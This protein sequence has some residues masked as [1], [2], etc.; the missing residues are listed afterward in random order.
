LRDTGHSVTA[1]ARFLGVMM[2]AASI[3]AALAV[4]NSFEM[5][6]AAAANNRLARYGGKRHQCPGKDD[7]AMGKDSIHEATVCHTFK[8][9]CRPLRPIN[10]RRC[11]NLPSNALF[12]PQRGFPKNWMRYSQFGLSFRAAALFASCRIHQPENQKNREVL[13]VIPRAISLQPV[14]FN[15]SICW[16]TLTDNADSSD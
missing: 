3:V 8:L 7:P 12:H 5:S 6:V 9:L 4:A 2:L 14:R 16:R 11:D 13:A 15:P 1:A 10:F